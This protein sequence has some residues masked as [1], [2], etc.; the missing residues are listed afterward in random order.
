ML[1]FTFTP[2]PPYDSLLLSPLF[3]PLYL[4][5]YCSL[6]VYHL[7]NCGAELH[8]Y[9]NTFCFFFWR[10]LACLPLLGSYFPLK[11]I[12]AR[13]FMEL[14]RKNRSMP[15]RKPVESLSP[16]PL[17][18][19]ILNPVSRPLSDTNLVY[20]GSICITQLQTIYT[21][22]KLITHDE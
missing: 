6:S 1:L 4:C 5:L 18:R 13:F 20:V 21:R 3:S 7:V 2:T 15:T 19:I 10:F 9:Q 14:R 8:P 22:P 16:N 12:K 11:R 17:L